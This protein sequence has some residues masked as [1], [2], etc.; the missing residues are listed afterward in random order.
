MDMSILNNL[1]NL[2]TP[3]VKDAIPV[4]ES[5]IRQFAQEHHIFLRE[6][7]LRLL[8]RFSSNHKG[9]VE[10]FRSYGGDF[11]F[12]QFARVYAENHPD[13]ALPDGYTYFGSS[14]VGESYCIEHVSGKI[15]TYDIGERYGMVHESIAGFLLSCFLTDDNSNAFASRTVRQEL[16][17]TTFTKFRLANA[18]AKISE[19][20]RFSEG[21]TELR[22][23]SEFYLIKGQLIRLFLPGRSIVTLSGGV[24]EFIS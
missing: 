16:D 24:L 5:E 7:H 10:I 3:F 9:R 12:E 21:G 22:P 19:A 11:D 15:Y 20:T 6:D 1:V 2:L 23:E 13:M 14:F 4:A 17:V 8:M 18:H